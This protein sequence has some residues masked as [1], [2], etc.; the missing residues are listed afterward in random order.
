[1]THYFKQF[2]KGQKHLSIQVCSFSY[3]YKFMYCLGKTPTSW[4]CFART[5]MVKKS[6]EN[7]SQGDMDFLR[8]QVLRV[9]FVKI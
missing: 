7:L 2:F 3:P 8:Q 9:D 6:T 4:L 1:M 5:D